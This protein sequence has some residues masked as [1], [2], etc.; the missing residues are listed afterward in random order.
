MA[1]LRLQFKQNSVLWSAWKVCSG[2][3]RGSLKVCWVL[4]PTWEELKDQLVVAVDFL[5][6]SLPPTSSAQ[7]TALDLDTDQVV[8]KI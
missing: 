2:L 4:E 8:T 3:C 1:S 5:S 7:V 6:T